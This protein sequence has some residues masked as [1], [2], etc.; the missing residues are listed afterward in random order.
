MQNVEVEAG[1]EDVGEGDGD[2]EH[3]SEDGKI[4]A[5]GFAVAEEDGEADAGVHQKPAEGGSEAEPAH[6]IEVADDDGRGAVRD[7]ADDDGEQGRDIAVGGKE[8]H[9]SVL[10]D[11][12]Y[13]DAEDQVDDEDIKEGPRAVFEGMQEILAE[14]C[15]AVFG[16]ELLFLSA[17]LFALGVIVLALLLVFFD[18]VPAA[19]DV[20]LGLVLALGGV[21]FD[22][23]AAFCADEVRRITYDE[24]DRELESEDGQDVEGF[25]A[26]GKKDG[27]RLV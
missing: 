4:L 2:E 24:P 5:P 13:D 7:G 26:C 22:A 14:F 21:I 15:G 8:L 3:H 10:A 23:G 20:D 18:V 11:E 6:E 1:G 12:M 25:F 9:Q 19:P 27:E 16:G 17:G